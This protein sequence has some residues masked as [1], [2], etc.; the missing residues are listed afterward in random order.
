MYPECLTEEWRGQSSWL[1]PRKNGPEVIKGPGGVTT[2]PT[3]LGPI[4][5]LTVVYFFKYF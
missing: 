4:Y 1:H 2:S 5:L 3:L